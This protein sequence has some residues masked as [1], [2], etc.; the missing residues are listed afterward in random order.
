MRAAIVLAAGRSLRF[1][2]ADK[3]RATLRGRSLLEHVLLHARASG[4]GRIMVVGGAKPRRGAADHRI[5]RVRAPRADVGIGTS[6]SAALAA[7]RP[8]EREVVIF[9]ADMPFAAVPHGLRL[10]AGIDAARPIVDGRPG[11]PVLIRTPVARAL[12][13]AGDEGLVQGLRRLPTALVAG[14][15]GNLLDID[16]VPDFRRARLRLKGSPSMKRRC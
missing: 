3:L 13:R 9:L 8:I 2:R 10:T 4:A 14:Q 1:G 5:V 6:L 12:C 7:L 15:S 16:T 11:H